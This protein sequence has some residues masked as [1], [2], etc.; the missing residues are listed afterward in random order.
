MVTGRPQ[1]AKRAIEQVEQRLSKEGWPE[2][3]DGKAGRYVRKQARKGQEDSQAK[4]HPLRFL[5][6]QTSG[7]S[8]H[9]ALQLIVALSPMLST[10]IASW[11]LKQIMAKISAESLVALMAQRP[12]L[13]PEGLSS[14]SL[15]FIWSIPE[16]L[17][18]AAL[19]TAFPGNGGFVIWT[20]QAFG[21]FWASLLVSGSFLLLS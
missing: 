6:S 21:P 19:A 18:T 10:L 2:Y 11:P 14:P 20:H 16:A 8:I 1:T 9:D 4:A 7:S 5:L 3:Y 12:L 17:V 15:D 13:A